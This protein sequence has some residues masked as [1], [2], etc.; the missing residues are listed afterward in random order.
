MKIH[1]YL[2]QEL[3]RRALA[4]AVK[5]R[6]IPRLSH[7][8]DLR[9]KGVWR[10]SAGTVTRASDLFHQGTSF[11]D[12]VIAQEQPHLHVPTHN[13]HFKV[14]TSAHASVWRELE[15]QCAV[16]RLNCGRDS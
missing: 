13:R 2:A 3:K 8:H 1:L 12:L 15:E 16:P 9:R 7:V 6:V 5:L 10:S 4:W 11:Q 14:H